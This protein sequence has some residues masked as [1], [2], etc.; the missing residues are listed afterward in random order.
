MKHRL[1]R[2]R[3]QPGRERVRVCVTIMGV[4]R[5]D[6]IFRH[7]VELEEIFGI[8]A[9]KLYVLLAFYIKTR[10]EA[11]GDSSLFALA[12]SRALYQAF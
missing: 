6:L 9:F 1:R 8:Q 10:P 2:R 12:N 3:A 4:T 5:E 7:R 11:G